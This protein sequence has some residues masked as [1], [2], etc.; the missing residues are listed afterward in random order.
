[1]VC[2]IQYFLDIIHFCAI[3]NF[4]VDEWATFK[5]FFIRRDDQAYWSS[6]EE[7]WHPH[8]IRGDVCGGNNSFPHS[9]YICCTVC[10]L[11][12]QTTSQFVVRVRRYPVIFISLAWISLFHRISIQYSALQEHNWSLDINVP[13]SCIEASNRL[14]RIY[15]VFLLGV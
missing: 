14:T 9:F 13:F 5:I 4:K 10:T 15:G 7:C 1:M 8:P 6:L 12:L 3:H 11:M 2:D